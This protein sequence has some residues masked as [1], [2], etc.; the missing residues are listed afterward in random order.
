MNPVKAFG[1]VL[2]ETRKEKGISQEKFA[3]ICGM[4]R[5]FISML[6]RG[7]RQPTLTS[8]LTI[9]QALNVKPSKLIDL[10]QKKSSEQ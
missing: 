1:K 2:S 7:L 10:V 8:I 3:E 4:D 6:E 5:T 9:A